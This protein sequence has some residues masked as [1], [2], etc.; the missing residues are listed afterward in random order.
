MVS[1]EL[2]MWIRL[3][4]SLLAFLDQ[5][6]YDRLGDEMVNPKKSVDVTVVQKLK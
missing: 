2:F 6:L 3:S 1:V 5:R 4:Q